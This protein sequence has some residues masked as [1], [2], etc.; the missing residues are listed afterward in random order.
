LGVGRKEWENESF[1]EDG[2]SNMARKMNAGMQIWNLNRMIADGSRHSTDQVDVKA[3]FDST[4]T[5]SENRRN[6]A[7]QIGMT[8]RNY[9]LEQHTQREDERKRE[10]IRRQDKNRQV[11]R[12]NLEIDRARSAKAPG[13]R[14]AEKSKRFY[15]EYRQNR[16]DVPPGK[17]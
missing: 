10:H 3:L 11:G 7:K 8:T 5:L 4:L 6:I 12:S 13:K 2:S 9:G 14:Q 1:R 16:T 17:V 15:Y